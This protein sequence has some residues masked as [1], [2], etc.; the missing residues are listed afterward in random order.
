MRMQ[1][2][3]KFLKQSL[4]V[5][6]THGLRENGEKKMASVSSIKLDVWVRERESQKEGLQRHR[7][8]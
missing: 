5:K 2:M 3:L 4:K 8:G 6:I 7:F 1:P